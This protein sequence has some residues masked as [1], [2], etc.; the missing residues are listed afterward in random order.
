MVGTRSRAIRRG[1]SNE[2]EYAKSLGEGASERRLE[3][4]PEQAKEA[5]RRATPDA[6]ERIPTAAV[7]SWA[8][9]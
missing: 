3:H 8:I 4:M 7:S 5:W 1:T 2:A 6:R 9:P